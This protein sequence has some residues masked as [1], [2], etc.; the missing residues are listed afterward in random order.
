MKDS[1][2]SRSLK[3]LGWLIASAV[4]T[5]VLAYLSSDWASAAWYPVVYWV[6]TTARD[7]AD[8]S[9]PNK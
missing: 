4:V 1:T 8:K 5:A 2:T 6:L 9:V 7:F 3:R